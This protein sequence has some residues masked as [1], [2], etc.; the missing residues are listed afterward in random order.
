MVTSFMDGSF[1]AVAAV[2]LVLWSAAPAPAAADPGQ[3][4]VLIGE[5]QEYLTREADTFIDIA[6]RFGLGYVELAI[7]NPGVDPWVPG[8]DVALRLPLARLLPEAPHDGIVIN[9]AEQR[10]YYFSKNGDSNSYPIGTGIEGWDTPLGRTRIVRKRANPT[11]Y[12]PAS[13]RKQDPSLPAAVPPGPDNPL[14]KYALDLGWERYVVHGTNKPAGIGRRVSHGCIRLYPEDIAA[15]FASVGRGTR[16]TVVDQPLKLGWSDGRLYME[17][18]PTQAQADEFEE[19]GSFT[20]RLVD[21]L[22]GKIAAAAR[23]RP[24]GV[25]WAGIDWDAV[26]RA[27]GARDGV[28]VAITRR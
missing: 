18:H 23:K 26:E 28:P 20:P 3:H 16:V 13:I 15:L 1:A 14:G 8:E 19:I 9:I 10:L 7:A 12:V 2:G 11:W 24:Y 21:G 25:G 5:T 4:P 22:R 27:V 17:I 6:R